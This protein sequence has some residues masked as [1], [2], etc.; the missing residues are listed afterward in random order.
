MQHTIKNHYKKLKDIKIE[1]K[2]ILM[3][4]KGVLID[5]D[6]DASQATGA[7]DI[8]QAK[9]FF[10]TENGPKKVIDKDFFYYFY[11]EAPKSSIEALAMEGVVKVEEVEKI[12]NGEK[13][14]V[15]KVYVAHPKY[16][17]LDLP[18]KTYQKD[19]PFW[20]LY[21]MEK[22]LYPLKVYEVEA[23]EFAGENPQE[24][25]CLLKS[26]KQ[27]EGE[28]FYKDED[29]D[30]F[31]FD[32]ETY[33]PNREPDPAKD[34][35]IMLS[36]AT[37]KETKVITTQEP[38]EH[39]EFVEKV[40]SE[41]DIIKKFIQL[42]DKSDLIVGYN[43]FGFD[44]PYIKERA[45]KNKIKIIFS[46]N[47]TIRQERKGLVKTF[48]IPGKYLIDFYLVIK[49][50][51]IVGAQANLLRLPSFSLEKVYESITGKK[52]FTVEKKDIYKLWDEGRIVELSR[53][54]F[55]DSATLFELFQK[56]SP[57]LFELSRLVG[58]SPYEVS[59]STPGQLVEFFLI[60]KS[61]ENN[62]LIPNKPSE[63]EVE[64]RIN[65]QVEGA[66]VKTPE[67]G[68]YS[69]IWVCDFRSMYPSIIVAHNIS[70]SSLVRE[71]GS[72]EILK[73]EKGA[74]GI[75][76]A[77]GRKE[78]SGSDAGLQAL[79]TAGETSQYFISPI[80]F[81]FR[82][83]PKETIPKSL[84]GL[85]QQRKKIK[86]EM[87]QNPKD[88]ILV[89]RS[90]AL[91]IIANAFYGYLGYARSRFYSKECTASIT[92]YG[93]HYIH[94]IMK[95]AEEK[96]IKVI[97]GDTDSI[98]IQS[99]SKDEVFGF[100]NEINKLLPEGMELEIEGFYPRGVFVSKRNVDELGAKKKYA[101]LS[102]DGSI[103]IKGFEF[104]RRDWSRIAKIAQQKVLEAILKKGSKEEAV[105]ELQR[106]IQ[107]LKANKIEI[108]DLVI[109]TRLRKDLQNYDVTSPE[110]AAAVKAVRSGKK[111]QKEIEGSVI[112]YVIT[113]QGSTISEKATLEE[114]AKD[115]DPEYYIEHQVLPAALKILAELGVTKEDILGEKQKKL[116]K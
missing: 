88:L 93:R 62:E 91:K 50:L 55:S 77:K 18:F 49:F 41:K 53:Y 36:Y 114:F 85:L 54:S 113:R 2:N 29:F 22:G 6:I 61:F 92:A 44:I 57:I 8:A 105:K 30:V 11:V 63:E 17:K 72:R 110:L 39:L 107:D 9:L 76:E 28:Q 116:F 78:G 79:G 16:A 87:K 3:L 13:I 66:F 101:L 7:V 47:E 73:K 58:V 46:S 19:I 115:Y 95:K 104:V 75:S 10:K 51:S 24:N 67:P 26:I 81:K 27:V 38:S 94:L 20:L 33:N 34:K 5:V 65:K 45:E 98:F 74:N 112:G 86:Q 69:D 14:K 42:S 108:K 4:F 82:K 89:A 32:I 100:V 71:D 80:G 31:C 96:G 23:D 12:Y 111:T 37:N 59:V 84:E 43:S 25:A 40:D 83:H 48:K 64:S 60:R 15:S 106:I 70:P 99:P 90:Q 56:F 102:E 35:I 21:L 68:I 103:K 97:Y 109:Y 52:K 1:C